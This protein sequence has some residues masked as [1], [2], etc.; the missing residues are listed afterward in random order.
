MVDVMLPG[1]EFEMLCLQAGDYEI[2]DPEIVWQLSGALEL[3]D[4]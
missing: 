4:L 3:S 2:G 1:N